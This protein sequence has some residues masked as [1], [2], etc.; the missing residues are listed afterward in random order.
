MRIDRRDQRGGEHAEDVGETLVDE[1]RW[2]RVLAER[3]GLQPHVVWAAL[4]NFAAALLVGTA[5]ASSS[6]S[7]SPVWPVDGVLPSIFDSASFAAFFAKAVR[8][9]R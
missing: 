3:A 9:Q 8:I 5:V 1:E 7:R 2:W 4:G 6:P